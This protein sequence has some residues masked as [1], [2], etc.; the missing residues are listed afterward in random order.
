[1]TVAYFRETPGVAIDGN[2]ANASVDA[3]ELADGRQIIVWADQVE[4][5]GAPVIRGQFLDAQG[6]PAGEPVNLVE[7]YSVV[8]DLVATSAGFTL[9]YGVPYAGQLRAF[10]FNGAPV[11]PSVKLS[12]PYAQLTTLSDGNVLAIWGEN[13]AG[14]GERLMGQLFSA[15]GLA[16]GAAELLVAEV[17]GSLDVVALADGAFV[18]AYSSDIEW[19]DFV[20]GELTRITTR[21][22]DGFGEAGDASIFHGNP[23][24]S[25]SYGNDRAGKWLNCFGPSLAAT[26][27]GYALV[28]TESFYESFGA[29]EP[30]PP[31]ESSRVRGRVIDQGRAYPEFDVSS[32][33]SRGV[34]AELSAGPDGSL[35]VAGAAGDDSESRT[36]T[37]QALASDGTL[38]GE[39]I[40]IGE[41]NAR[42]RPDIALGRLADGDLFAIVA[43]R[44]PTGAGSF[45][46]D[47]QRLT[48][49][50]FASVFRGSAGEDV[51][52][53]TELADYLVGLAGNDRLSGGGGDDHIGGGAG[54]DLLDGG[55]GGDRINGG[56]GDDL[57]GGGGGDDHIDGG[58]GNDALDG[59]DGDDRVYGGGGNDLLDG[60]GGVDR[61]AGGAGDDRYIQGAG[62]SIVE[63]AGQGTDTLVASTDVTTLTDEVENL[64]LT[65]GA[66]EGGGNDGH[67]VITGNSLDNRLYGGGG[68][69]RLSGGGGDDRLDGQA[70]H[71]LLLGRAGADLLISL[72]GEDRLFGGSGDDRYELGAGSLARVIEGGGEGFDTIVAA[73]S[74]RLSAHVEALE[75]TG[76]AYFG[77]GNDGDNIITGTSGRNRLDGGRGADELIGLGG[78]D[79]L[80]GADLGEA[81]DRLDGGEGDDVYH[82]DLIDVIVDAGCRD[83]VIVAGSYALQEGLETLVLA[84]AGD[85]NGTGNSGSNLILGNGGDNGISG[86]GGND[87]L[88]G[89][90]GND[91]LSGGAGNDRLDAGAGADLLEGGAGNDRLAGGEGEDTGSWA[92][93]AAAAAVDLLV[94]EA[95]ITGD[96]RDV[97]SGIEHLVGSAFSD[98]LSGDLIANR[99]AGGDGND[100]LRGRDGND[101]LAGGGGDDAL[102]GGNHDDGLS[103]GDGQDF[104]S[105]QNSD[106]LIDGGTG[107]DRLFGGDGADRMDGG[108]GGD[109]MD[110]GTGDDIYVV[111]DAADRVIEQVGGGDDVVLAGVDHILAAEVEQLRLTG[112]ARAGTGNGLANLINGS[113]LDNAIAGEGGDDFIFGR[114]GD[115]RLA[116]GDGRDTIDAGAGRDDVSGDGGEDR[117]SGG[118]EADRIDGGSE[119]D[120]LFGDDGRDLLIGGGGDDLLYGG[121]DRDTLRGGEGADGFVFREGETGG[122][123][124]TADCIADFAGAEGDR[125]DLHRID[126]SFS[127]AGDQAF[128]FIGD[129]DFSG[130][131]G[132]LR[133]FADG[134]YTY[135]EG[136]RD[137]DGAADIML[138]LTGEQALAATDFIV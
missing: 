120:R 53:G 38:I 43:G 132:E 66:I 61:L 26:P 98:L 13:D 1:M 63:L 12:G 64:D 31:Y 99:I 19:D 124:L 6:A 84:G 21:R 100:R 56:D 62:G 138:C 16:L 39:Q 46:V 112:A 48:A 88:R 23:E 78:N 70:E 32:A 127:G 47:L 37:G 92:G 20:D 121:F 4:A 11:S 52:A 76:S 30:E 97:L 15:E 117:L 123:A 126:A 87:T 34:P 90:E 103:G 107:D 68:Y 133:A 82:V 129:A 5:T 33:E 134:G 131:A 136:D 74:H 9:S 69:D 85:A 96:G 28:W 122:S 75:L 3:V 89:A 65:G 104:V 73:A 80:F 95:Q 45:M 110:G 94:T 113:D 44:S 101:V 79:T 105:G 8:D 49:H 40:A 119:A 83:R 71:D 86:L 135:V 137:G 106:D 67:N 128:D 55:G 115:D 50:D 27:T 77:Y 72:E 14:P 35:F 93:A 111:D 54:D 29:G 51:A 57:L 81:A 58:D 108:G 59:G 41:P 116:G 118:S 24:T 109:A 18:V 22:F 2:T 25:D 114:S 130:V 17:Y 125:I 7:G 91:E 36:A 10:N 102:S 60:G 42:F